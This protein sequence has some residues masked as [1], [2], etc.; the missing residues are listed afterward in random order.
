MSASK[1]RWLSTK[2]TLPWEFVAS[3]MDKSLSFSVYIVLRHFEWGLIS[4]WTNALIGNLIF[5]SFTSLWNIPCCL[6]SLAPLLFK[7]QFDV[8][9]FAKM[10]V[11]TVSIHVCVCMYMCVCLLAVCVCVYCI[12]SC[13]CMHVHVCVLISCVCVCGSQRL[14]RVIFPQTLHFET[15]SLDLKLGVWAILAGQPSP[16]DL[17]VPIPTQRCWSTRY[18]LMGSGDS[19][20][21]LTHA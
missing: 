21:A 14:M 5:E 2:F 20:Q 11:C 13:V 8:F 9:D 15:S 18:F 1:D 6:E 12:H 3:K 10:C 16:W 19:R 7:L 4:F 17:P